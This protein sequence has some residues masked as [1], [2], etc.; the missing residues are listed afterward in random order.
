MNCHFLSL[1]KE[2]CR[3]VKNQKSK[4]NEINVFKIKDWR[5]AI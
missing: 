5:S 3:N 4:I 1:P 2:E